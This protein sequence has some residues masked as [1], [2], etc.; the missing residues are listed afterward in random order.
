M[1][2]GRVTSF[3]TTVD[4]ALFSWGAGVHGELGVKPPDSVFK[5][6]WNPRWLVQAPIP[7]PF[8]GAGSHK[9]S[10]VAA[11]DMHCLAL[12]TDGSVRVWGRN[13]YGQLGLEGEQQWTPTLLEGPW[14]EKEDTV[15]Q[16][17]VGDHH[18]LALTS[19]G[20]VY[21]WGRNHN[22]QLGLG[23]TKKRDTPALIRSCVL[24][25]DGA[26][27]VASLDRFP[28]LMISAGGD[29]S[30]LVHHPKFL[31]KPKP[32]KP[33]AE[34]KAKKRGNP[35]LLAK[36]KAKKRK[37]TKADASDEDTESDEEAPVVKKPKKKAK[38]ASKKR[39]Q[40]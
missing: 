12:M 18:C 30:F 15:T 5:N 13:Q 39:K 6:A 26:D 17:A 10:R 11:G 25:E 19:A 1:A 32:K 28:P 2:A 31:A 23:D 40:K 34:G 20:K 9:V 3:A 8:A 35:K 14:M 27:K 4:G 33:P 29:H 38:K 16:V 36:A 37:M 21:S 7:V 22:G 24:P